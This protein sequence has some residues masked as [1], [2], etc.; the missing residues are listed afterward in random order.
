MTGGWGIS[1]GV[2]GAGMISM[3]GSPGKEAGSVHSPTGGQYPQVLR[4]GAQPSA[5]AERICVPS[6]VST[7]WTCTCPALLAVPKKTSP[8][9]S[10]F[11]SV[12]ELLRGPEISDCHDVRRRN[13]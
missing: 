5:T 4:G 1:G 3:S 11:T 10:Q 13:R 2:H 12:V 8:L 9:R 7:I 6:T